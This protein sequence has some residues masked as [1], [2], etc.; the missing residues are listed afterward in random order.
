[1]NTSFRQHNKSLRRY[2]HALSI[3]VV[4]L[5]SGRKWGMRRSL[6]NVRIKMSD[7]DFDNK[8]IHLRA[9]KRTRGNLSGIFYPTCSDRETLKAWHNADMATGVIH[10]HSLWQQTRPIPSERLGEN[11]ILA[12]YNGGSVP[13]TC[14][15]FATE[16]IAAGLT[17][18]R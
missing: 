6:R 16:A 2:A 15:A 8:V 13:M 17:L 18:E 1:M 9:A 14:H 5:S 12:G 11:L 4:L 3:S 7:V 10:A